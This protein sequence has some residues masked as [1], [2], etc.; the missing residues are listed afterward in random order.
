MR[1]VVRVVCLALSLRASAAA[2]WLVSFHD[3]YASSVAVDSTGG[4]VVGAAIQSMTVRNQYDGLVIKLSAVSGLE[5][6][7]RTVANGTI[8]NLVVDSHGDVIAAGRSVGASVLKLSGVTGSETWRYVLPDAEFSAVAVDAHGD[9]VA[10]GTI[11]GRIPVL[12]SAFVVVMLD[13]ADG[14]ERWRRQLPP[15]SEQPSDGAF[16]VAVD[17]AG[18][19]V[20]CGATKPAAR[21]PTAFTVLKLSGRTGDVV[22]RRAMRGTGRGN[23]SCGAL[24]IDRSGHVVAVGRTV[25]AETENSFTMVKLDGANGRGIWRRIVV[26]STHRQR[27][28]AR[29]VAITPNGDV[30][31]AG[32]ISNRQ[33]GV[34]VAVV[35]VAGATGL[36]RWRR[37]IHGRTH[38]SLRDPPFPGEGVWDLAVDSQGDVVAAGAIIDAAPNAMSFMVTKLARTTGRVRWLRLVGVSGGSLALAVAVTPEGNVVAAG[39]LVSPTASN[40]VVVQLDGTNGELTP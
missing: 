15:S 22:W 14:S 25:N 21:R 4:V 1:R 27:A 32:S 38:E 5:I 36:L 8:G 39:R 24:A 17:V 37:M 19:V 12:S 20:A 26:G 2:A 33:S 34:D 9:V 3:G 30:I 11:I 10:V 6:W 13:G 28:R 23:D 31:A 35:K 40:P 7:R 16:G 29:V 18:D